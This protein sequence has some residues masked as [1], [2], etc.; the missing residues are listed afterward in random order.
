MS[1]ANVLESVATILEANNLHKAGIHLFTFDDVP[2]QELHNGYII[3]AEINIDIAQPS[4]DSIYNAE[5]Q[6]RIV[7]SWSGSENASNTY[8]E[9][10]LDLLRFSDTLESA[11]TSDE[12]KVDN[13]AVGTLEGTGDNWLVL[14]LF[15]ILNATR[16]R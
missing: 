13:S 11:L 2:T 5:T 8:F 15:L 9:A 4:V 6:V 7:R 3:P 12:V 1:V 16:K 10:I 14:T